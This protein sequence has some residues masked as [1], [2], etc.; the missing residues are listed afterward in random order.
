VN[1]IVKNQS[2]DTVLTI[3]GSWDGI[4]KI[5]HIMNSAKETIK[6]YFPD[7]IIYDASAIDQPSIIE[8]NDS[9]DNL[10]TSKD[11]WEKVSVSIKNHDFTQADIEKHKVEANQNHYIK[12]LL[13]N[14][15]DHQLVFFDKE[16]NNSYSLKPSHDAFLISKEDLKKIKK[17]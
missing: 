9:R 11:I 13:K 3:N 4:I 6:N 1:G 10:K 14:E 15:S 16:D 8:Y 7:K 2:G 5:S 12:E 17:K